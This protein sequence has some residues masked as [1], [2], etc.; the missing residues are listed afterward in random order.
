[1]PT[2]QSATHRKTTT[3]TDFRA[4][5]ISINHTPQQRHCEMVSI[6]NFS[7]VVLRILPQCVVLLAMVCPQSKHREH[8]GQPISIHTQMNQL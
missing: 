4:Y 5:H 6:I 1:M 2:Y 8:A 7:N 3:L